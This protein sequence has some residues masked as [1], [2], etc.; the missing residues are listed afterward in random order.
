M[1]P[2]RLPLALAFAAVALAALAAPR[3]ASADP[4][5]DQKQQQL[6]D[7]QEAVAALDDRA[8]ALTEQFNAA[9][10]RLGRLRV[11]IA[12]ATQRLEAA[13]RELVRREAE[14]ASRQAQLARLIVASYKGSDIHTLDILLGSSTLDE[15]TG[16]I[17]LQRRLEGAVQ[18]AVVAVHE[19]VREVRETRD[20]IARERDVL[21]RSEREV[22]TQAQLLERTR[23]Q[24]RRQLARRRELLARV[25]DEVAVLEAASSV[26][27]SKVALEMQQWLVADE[28]ANRLDPGAALGDQ[29]AL[30]ALQQLGVPY[31]W[32]GATPSGFDC[33]GL[34]MWL[35]ARHGVT[36]PHFAAAQYHQGPVILAGDL[37]PGD[38]VFFHELGHVGMYIGN[39][40]VVHAPHTGDFVRIEALSI[41]WFQATYVGA[42]RPG[43]A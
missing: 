24:V 34:T 8:E 38:L 39:G 31:K 14:L 11:R 40:Y 33:S 9:R 32:G 28:R 13:Q 21:E 22:A 35:Y 37:R 27:Q 42:T 4:L 1:G 2:R 30:D 19:A 16:G 18:D 12:D 29:V 25:G 36:L 10:W 3:P 41:P 17:D 20:R 6:R 7:T 15:V 26:N 5:L 43:P 23:V